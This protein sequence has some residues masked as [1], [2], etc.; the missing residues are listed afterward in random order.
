MSHFSVDERTLNCVKSCYNVCQDEGDHED[1]RRGFPISD[2]ATS[3]KTLWARV[4]LALWEQILLVRG[5][6]FRARLIESLMERCRD[7]LL[8]YLE[9]IGSPVEQGDWRCIM[10]QRREL[11]GCCCCLH[12]HRWGGFELGRI[13]ALCSLMLLCRWIEI[14]ILSCVVAIVFSSNPGHRGNQLK[15]SDGNTD[16]L[17][18][19]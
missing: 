4:V 11:C 3:N 19:L 13:A 1:S 12:G 6:F 5:L 16:R 14:L 2:N 8:D 17:S 10:Y 7:G 15:L 9:L 18:T